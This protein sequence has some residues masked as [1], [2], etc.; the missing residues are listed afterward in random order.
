MVGV[1]VKVGVAVRVGVSVK[2]G[3]ELGVRVEV[4]VMVRVAVAPAPPPNLQEVSSNG[5]NSKNHNTFLAMNLLY[6]TGI[7]KTNEILH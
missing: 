3:V 7:N 4:G 2:V 6:C 5:T 1:E